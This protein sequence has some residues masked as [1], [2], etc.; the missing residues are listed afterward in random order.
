MGDIVEDGWKTLNEA[1][2]FS[3]RTVMNTPEMEV[4]VEEA[5]SNEEWGPT[6]SQLTEIA[7]ASF[8]YSELP[9]IMGTLYRR[10]QDT[11]KN[12]RHVYKSLRVMEYLLTHGS[13][14]SIRSL[15][16]HSLE[17]QQLTH[18]HHVD[19]H[20][21][22]GQA[23]RSKAKQVLELIHDESKLRE[24]REKAKKNRNK[25][26]GYGSESLPY[27]G[28][29]GYEEEYSRNPYEQRSPYE[30]RRQETTS[31]TYPRRTPKQE[32]SDTDSDD[33]DVEER[34]I[35]RTPPTTT[36]TRG[37]PRAPSDESERERTVRPP[38][39]T[40]TTTQ[41]KNLLFELDEPSPI[42]TPSPFLP[43]PHGGQASSGGNLFDP[44]PATGPTITPFPPQGGGSGG[45]APFQQTPPFNQTAPTRPQVPEE[46]WD[47]FKSFE[48]PRDQSDIW[49]QHKSLFDLQHLNL[50]DTKEKQPPKPEEKRPLG[51]MLAE[52][53]KNAKPGPALNGGNPATFAPFGPSTPVLPKPGPTMLPA[54][55]SMPSGPVPLGG[56]VYT[57]SGMVYPGAPV[58]YPYYATAPGQQP[59]PA[60]GMPY[61]AGAK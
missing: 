14:D 15:R 53:Q 8:R 60:F 25:Y 9:L 12:W 47:G 58:A 4:K 17:L 44:F 20:K 54:S 5:T 52:K 36:A 31:P 30:G 27:R 33:S 46:E 19:E 26:Q 32:L 1:W 40:T 55:L 13:D 56:P 28:R 50:A 59:P 6:S 42:T 61:Y 48:T 41:S 24:E 49:Y 43:P 39:A 11:G 2:K 3:K 18:F 21:D 38:P 29:G 22:V 7:S 35:R 10:I 16:A 57:T 37:R 34:T 51:A 23:I 45:F